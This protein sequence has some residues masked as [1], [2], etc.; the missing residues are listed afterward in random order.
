MK[1][2]DIENRAIEKSFCASITT[3]FI[4]LSSTSRYFFIYRTTDDPVAPRDGK[5]RIDLR[6]ENSADTK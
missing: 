4:L 2:S 3:A 5:E 6:R 1:R